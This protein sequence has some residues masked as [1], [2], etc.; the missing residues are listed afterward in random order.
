MSVWLFCPLQPSA[1]PTSPLRK[2]IKTKKFR[3]AVGRKRG[4]Y[5]DEKYMRRFDEIHKQA[6]GDEKAPKGGYPDMGNGRYSADLSYD[7]WFL[8]NNAQRAH[9]NF[10]EQLTPTLVWLLISIFYQP[11]AAAI[12]GFVVVLGR[13]FYAVGY[14][15]TPNLRSVGAL[16]VDLGFLGLFVLSLVSIGNWM[17]VL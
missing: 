8:F 13:I 9:Y 11:L 10:L 2:T 15:K 6:T 14:F 16:L 3:G 5:F 12:L 7:Q 1:S 17:N 4:Q